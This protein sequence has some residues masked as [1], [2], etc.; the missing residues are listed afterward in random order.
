MIFFSGAFRRINRIQIFQCLK[1]FFFLNRNFIAR[2]D[3][4]ACWWPSKRWKWLNWVSFC[5]PVNITTNVNIIFRFIGCEFCK[6]SSGLI[7][8]LSLTLID[9]SIVQ[10]NQISGASDTKISQHT[11]IV[12]L[13][14][15]ILETYSVDNSWQKKNRK[16]NVEC[17]T[18]PYPIKSNK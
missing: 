11:A 1:L 16:K 5:P 15:T 18:R 3:R 10:S 17:K 6:R 13:F 12:L 14:I 4:Y 2:R 9:D 8:V 7:T